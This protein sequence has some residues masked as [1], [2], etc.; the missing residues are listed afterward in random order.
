[1]DVAWMTLNVKSN[2]SRFSRHGADVC[3]SHFCQ[4]TSDGLEVSR[5]LDSG[6]MAV[7][8]EEDFLSPEM[9]VSS[10]YWQPLITSITSPVGH[11]RACR[12]LN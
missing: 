6:A 1:M 4:L 2:V 8:C 10:R 9:E 12:S 11:G 7:V 3:Q 5:A